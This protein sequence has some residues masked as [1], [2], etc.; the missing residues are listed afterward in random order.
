MDR[1]SKMKTYQVDESHDDKQKDIKSHIKEG[2][3]MVMVGG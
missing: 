1:E 3:K 2:M